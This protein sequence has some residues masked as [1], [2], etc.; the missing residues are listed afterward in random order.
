M[1]V[2][3]RAKLLA[4]HLVIALAVGAVTLAVVDRQVSR[5]MEQ[6]LDQ[7]LEIQARAVAKWMERATHLQQLTRRLAEV[8]DARVTILDR[9]GVIRGDSS[10]A[11]PVGARAAE[12]AAELAAARADGLGRATRFSPAAGQ[13]V[14]Y[15][16]VPAPDD[17]VVRLGVPIGEIDEVKRGLRRQLIVAAIASA[18][19]A[20]GLAIAVAGPLSRRLREATAMARRLGAGDYALGAPPTARDEV[21]VLA[22]ALAGAGAE[23]GATERRRR[24][25]LADVAHE[26]RTPVT[27]IRGYADLLTRGH[28]D[29]D[30]R[31]E[32]LETIRRNAVRIGTLVD[33]LLELEAL[34]AGKGP[35][36]VRAP[37]ALGPLVERVLGTLRA[38]A[39]EAGATV[40][41]TL[42]P[43]LTVAADADAVERIALNLLDNA[44]R[45]GGAGVTVTVAGERVGDRGR[46]IV[47][48]DGPG[49]P[50]EHRARIFDRFVRGSAGRERQGSGLGLAIA[51]ELASA[52]GGSLTLDGGS[53]F[54]LDLPA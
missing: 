47:R 17:A 30:T 49:V 29:D 54:V 39:T 15:V 42:A 48:D 20:I 26:L 28:V 23:L 14:R 31:A 19:A 37:V 12:P 44:L 36:L 46:L 9:D 35:P 5:R 16:A 1:L 41:T 43:G 7:R 6:Q 27:S 24:E 3:F 8:V 51:R 2:S 18:L 4:S 33:D 34:E 22:H 40:T 11:E 53:T 38:R 10:A 13:E 25:F 21:G 32:F 50:V 45:H 52:M